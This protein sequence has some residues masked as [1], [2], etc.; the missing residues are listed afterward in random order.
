MG[1]C[2]FLGENAL[3]NDSFVPEAQLMDKC[4]CIEAFRAKNKTLFPS[5]RPSRQKKNLPSRRKK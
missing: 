2:C 5:S 3:K 1:Y 4:R